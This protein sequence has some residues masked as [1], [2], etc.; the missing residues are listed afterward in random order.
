MKSDA[1]KAS[2]L[3]A[4]SLLITKSDQGSKEVLKKICKKGPYHFIVYDYPPHMVLGFA[5]IVSRLF[6]TGWAVCD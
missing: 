1:V 3:N 6:G 2:V 5:K 4:A